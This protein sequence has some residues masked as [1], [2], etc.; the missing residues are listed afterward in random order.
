MVQTELKD[1]VSTYFH[2]GAQTGPSS[3]F[4]F[5]TNVTLDALR[6]HI[7]K[8]RSGRDSTTPSVATPY[9]ERPPFFNV[10]ITYMFAEK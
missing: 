6:N 2:G 8:E 4:S 10:Y 3:L 7:K 5:L 9:C 1:L